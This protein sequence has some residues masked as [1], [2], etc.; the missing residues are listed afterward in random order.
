MPIIPQIIGLFAV[1]MFLLSYQQKKRKNIIL[2]NAISRCLYILQ[3]LLL[4][5]FSGAVLDI[6]GTVSSVIA[7][8]KHTKFVQKHMTVILIAIN[9]CMILAGGMI[10]FINGSWLDLFSLAGVL[11]HTGAFWLND[12]KIIRRISLMGSPCWFIYNFFSQAYGSALG[13]IFTM[14]S[15]MIAMIRYK[16]PK[17]Q[18][19]E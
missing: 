2:F 4:G 9:G 14:C 5:A 19:K 7:G 10:A 13:D 12:E 8:K 18:T 3:Y 11:L 6:L 16:N 17:P 1:A 15:I